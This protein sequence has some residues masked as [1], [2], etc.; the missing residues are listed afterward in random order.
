MGAA[1][2]TIA[3]LAN[4]LLLNLSE[5]ILALDTFALLCVRSPVQM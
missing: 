4:L 2:G 5:P 1:T 3:I